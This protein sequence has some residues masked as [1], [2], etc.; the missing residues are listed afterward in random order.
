MSNNIRTIKAIIEYGGADA[1]DT[2][3]LTIAMPPDGTWLTGVREVSASSL[4]VPVRHY[5]AR[6][7]AS[8]ETRTPL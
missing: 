1:A 2:L 4:P 5:L 3:N 7:L 8:A 6:W